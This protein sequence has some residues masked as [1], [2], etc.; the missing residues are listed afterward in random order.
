MLH[1]LSI[2]IRNSRDIA[3]GITCSN[4]VSEDKLTCISFT[5][6]HEVKR[7]TPTAVAVA[8]ELHNI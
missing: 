3:S 8:L 5:A 2:P 7:F 1:S 4:P 6:L